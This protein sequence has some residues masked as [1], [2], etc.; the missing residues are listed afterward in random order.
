[1]NRCN[2]QEK[3]RTENAPQP[4]G[5]YSQ[6]IKATGNL[7]FVS[8]QI[9]L[10]P[11]GEM[12]DEDIHSQTR[13]VIE[14]IE[15]IVNEAGGELESIVK[16]MVYMKDLGQFVQMNTVYEEFFNKSKPARGAVQVAEIPKGALVAMEAIAVI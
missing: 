5:P 16:V 14:N 4:I 7:V 2:M 9:P 3:I 10:T 12:I 8:M 15:S 1:M 11:S 6:A 13:Q